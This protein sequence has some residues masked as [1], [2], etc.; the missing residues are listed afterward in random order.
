MPLL[1]GDAINTDSVDTLAGLGVP[2]EGDK[3]NNESKISS[4]VAVSG[5][6]VLQSLK[7]ISGL[8]AVCAVLVVAVVVF[9]IVTIGVI[10]SVTVVLLVVLVTDVL[11][12]GHLLK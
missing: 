5:V 4:Q 10:T 9:V 8:L 2:V 6:N 11:E 12:L 7:R 1:S 3:P